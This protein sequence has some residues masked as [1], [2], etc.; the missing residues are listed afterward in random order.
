MK[1]LLGIIVLSLLLSGNVYAEN[2]YLACILNLE[3]FKKIHLK[4]FEKTFKSGD[5]YAIR[6]VDINNKKSKIK[7]Y[8]Q[9]IGYD[10]KPS[11]HEIL[12]Q[13]ITIKDL[14]EIKLQTKLKSGNIDFDFKMNLI[15]SANN[16]KYLIEGSDYGT[17]DSKVVDDLS[18]KGNCYTIKS[19]KLFKKGLRSGFSSSL[20]K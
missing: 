7:V 17:K 8:E 12:S 2:I 18:F 3:N 6:F 19:K 4:D 14:S 13:K 15:S 16:E 20:V 9:F 11:L 1:K 5:P 10:V